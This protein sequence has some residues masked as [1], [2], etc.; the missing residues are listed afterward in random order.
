MNI[1]EKMIRQYKRMADRKKELGE[2]GGRI[3]THEYL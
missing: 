2:V 1:H 3:V